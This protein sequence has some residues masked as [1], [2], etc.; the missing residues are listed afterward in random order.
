MCVRQSN[1]AVNFKSVGKHAI[2]RAVEV[3]IELSVT[4]RGNRKL[5]FISWRRVFAEID[6]VKDASSLAPAE[7]VLRILDRIEPASP[8]LLGPR[9][10]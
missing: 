2:K 10:E 1:A 3:G 5:P 8:I 9:D 7:P 4:A 6:S